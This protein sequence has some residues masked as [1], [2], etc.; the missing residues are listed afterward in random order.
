MSIEQ[1][2]VSIA[3]QP[4]SALPGISRFEQLVYTSVVGGDSCAVMSG[5]V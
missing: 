2:V 4:L 1:A 5:R 3:G